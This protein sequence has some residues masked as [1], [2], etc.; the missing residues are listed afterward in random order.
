MQTFYVFD[1]FFN[2]AAKLQK[3]TYSENKSTSEIS[4]INFEQS[5]SISASINNETVD[6]FGG[7]L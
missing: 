7:N 3:G 5:A 6:V 4:A 1:R 2:V